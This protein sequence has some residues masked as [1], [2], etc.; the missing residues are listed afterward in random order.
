M[1][2]DFL[3]FITF[4]RRY[5]KSRLYIPFTWME[6][7]KDTLVLNIYQNQGRFAKPFSHIFVVATIG[8][9][10]IIAPQIYQN[11][12]N[13][14]VKE[15]NILS[16]DVESIS[17]YTI[18]AEEVRQLRGGEVIEH[19]VRE[20]ETLTSIAEMYGLSDNTVR[21]ENGLSDKQEPKVGDV[22]RILPTNGIRHQVAKG[23]TIQSI[24]K[25]YGLGD[26]EIQAIIDYPF[27]DFADDETFEL[28]VGQYL[29][30]PGGVKPQ[31][32]LAVKPKATYGTIT[33]DAGSVTGTGSFA[34]PASGTI[35]QGYSFYHKAIDIS[36]AGGVFAADSGKVVALGWDNTGYG[37]RII[38]D[39]G[40]GYQT[41]YAHLSSFN[42]VMGQ[43]VNRGD[44]IGV[45]GSTGR[46]TGVH[47][48]FE[49]RRD[50]VLL[51]PMNFL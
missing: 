24:G 15:Y 42:V 30:V 13:H 5:L 7:S 36:K 39:H 22:L 51:N 18:Q 44:Q 37:N 6:K 29:M 41:L 16:N 10:I 14:Y 38:I 20:G 17:L 46:S 11:K 48:H 50:G 19:T 8:F 31:P 2:R 4:L 40:N 25:K 28:A 3:S 27:N 1:F 35:T 45:K 32:T 12:P 23:E 47:L 43:S 49:I 26:T 34:W 9:F 21:W 33:P